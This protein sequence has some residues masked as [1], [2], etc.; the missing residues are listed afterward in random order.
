MPPEERLGTIEGR[1]F[2]QEV[3]S[4]AMKNRSAEPR[5]QR[6]VPQRAQHAANDTRHHHSHEIHFPLRGE[7]PCRWHDQLT[8]EWEYRGF[9][10]HEYHD[11]WVP[12]LEDGIDQPGDGCVKH[13]SS[14]G[15]LGLGK[16]VTAY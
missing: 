6:V 9:D 11:S 5:G 16:T 13:S 7:I 2:D 15:L 8:R 14:L 12:Q 4:V 1:L 10:G 3:P